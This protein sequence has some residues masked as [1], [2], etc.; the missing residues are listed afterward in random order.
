MEARAVRPPLRHATAQSR[1]R[2]ARGTSGGLIAFRRG[3]WGRPARC[4]TACRCG[5]PPVAARSA[6]M[7]AGPLECRR[8]AAA[9]APRCRHR[10][11]QPCQRW[12][13]PRTEASRACDRHGASSAL[14]EVKLRRL[15]HGR[16]GYPALQPAGGDAGVTRVSCRTRMVSGA[17]S[18]TDPVCGRPI[19]DICCL[20][21]HTARP[22][23]A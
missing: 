11:P 6:A 20:G 10:S 21:D 2:R 17:V 9:P 14:P 13:T 4:R 23:A 5:M 19:S 22:L 12:P 18:A 7:P 1:S 15:S 8:R 16:S 3:C